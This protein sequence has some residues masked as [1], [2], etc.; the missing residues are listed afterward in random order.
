[1]PDTLPH[2]PD[3]EV[4]PEE[5]SARLKSED[6]SLFLDVRTQPEIDTAAI[7]GATVVPMSDVPEVLD[8]LEEH[9][10]G[11]VVVFCHHGGR[12]MRVTQFLR[13]QGFADAWSMAGGIDAWA[14]RVDTDI[15]RY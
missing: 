14:Q 3:W 7:E 9:R 5:T 11:K 15:P 6:V 10:D 4:T 12:S 13:Q 8:R 1:M 2:D